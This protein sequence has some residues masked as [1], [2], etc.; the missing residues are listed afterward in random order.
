MES[1]EIGHSQIQNR[2]TVERNYSGAGRLDSSA[3]VMSGAE[4]PT[5]CTAPAT[6]A[7]VLNYIGLS[8]SPSLGPFFQTEN[9]SRLRG[10][11]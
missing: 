2:A 11:K 5:R 7:G 8:G 9:I 10:P 4:T 3:P 1:A 6:T